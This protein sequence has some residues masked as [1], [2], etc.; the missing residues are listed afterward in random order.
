M[1]RPMIIFWVL[2]MPS[3]ALVTTGWSSPRKSRLYTTTT[4][5]S[6]VTFLTPSVDNRNFLDTPVMAYVTK[7]GE[8]FPFFEIA[9]ALL[10]AIGFTGLGA[11]GVLGSISGISAKALLDA[12]NVFANVAL[13]G[14]ILKY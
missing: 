3:S 2:Q 9:I 1:K 14:A 4:G 10:V 11:T 6:K 7:N 5:V 8:D 12:W 13:P